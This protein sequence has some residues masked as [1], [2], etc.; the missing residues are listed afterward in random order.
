MRY[1]DLISYVVSLACKRELPLGGGLVVFRVARLFL[2]V[3]SLAS[4]MGTCDI[5]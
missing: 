4:R 5:N 3:I 2:D 1:R